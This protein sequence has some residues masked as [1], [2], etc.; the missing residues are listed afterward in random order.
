MSLP[1]SSRMKEI[2]TKLD[3]AIQA[4]DLLMVEIGFLLSE[5]HTAAKEEALKGQQEQWWQQLDADEDYINKH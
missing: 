2:E 5:L 1:I 4:A 3:A